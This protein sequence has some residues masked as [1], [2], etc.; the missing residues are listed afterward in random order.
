MDVTQVLAILYIYIYKC[1]CVRPFLIIPM[2]Q[3]SAKAPVSSRPPL[4]SGHPKRDHRS[5]SQRCSGAWGTRRKSLQQRRTSSETPAECAEWL[6]RK[7]QDGGILLIE[8]WRDLHCGVKGVRLC[9]PFCSYDMHSGPQGSPRRL[10]HLIPA[11]TRNSGPGRR[12]SLQNG[13]LPQG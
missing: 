3:L 13:T 10:Q 7:P 2:V 5:G 1:V 8:G 9:F 12:P 11:K 6:H 4:W